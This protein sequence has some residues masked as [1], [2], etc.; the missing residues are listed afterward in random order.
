MNS[1]YFVEQICQQDP[2]L[3]RASLD[4]DFLFTNKLLDIPIN[5]SIDN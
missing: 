1:F 4:V 2:N 3:H 5:I